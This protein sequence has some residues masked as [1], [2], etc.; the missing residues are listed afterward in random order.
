MRVAIALGSNLED[1]LFLLREARD[2]IRRLHD[3]EAP[4]LCSKVYETRPVDCPPGSPSFLNAVIEFSTSLPPFDL[5][6]ITQR[7][8]SDLGR[9]PDH[10]F[11]APRTMDFDLLYYGSLRI[12]HYSLTLPHPRIS[13]RLFVLTPLCDINPLLTLAGENR[14]ISELRDNIGETRLN[15]ICFHSYI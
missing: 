13:D 14:T 11:H 9:P 2:R 6:A 7:W 10:S 1:R 5:L 4:F 12:S 3:I 8:E 15:D